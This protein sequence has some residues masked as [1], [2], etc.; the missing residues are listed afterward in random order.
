MKPIAHKLILASCVIFSLLSLEAFSQDRAL[1]K[2]NWGVT[3]LSAANWIPW[4]AKDAKIYEK[5]GLD[6]RVDSVTARGKP[7]P[8][9]LAEVS[10]ARR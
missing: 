3:S 9:F 10:S 7:P 5:N 6:V 1:K 4:V 8:R 2:I